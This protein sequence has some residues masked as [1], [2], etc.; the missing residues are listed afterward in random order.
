MDADRG[1]IDKD[2][3]MTPELF[4]SPSRVL[5]SRFFHGSSNVEPPRLVPK[6][7]H[8]T[9]DVLTIARLGCRG[10]MSKISVFSRFCPHSPRHLGTV[11][12]ASSCPLETAEIEMH[13]TVLAAIVACLMGARAGS[14]GAAGTS[15]VG[16]AGAGSQGLSSV[17][18]A[19]AN[20]A[21]LNNSGNDP[22]GAGNSTKTANVPGT[23]TAGT[24]N[25][26]G[27]TR[28]RSAI[29]GGHGTIGQANGAGVS[30]GGNRIDGTVTNGPLMR[31][32][33]TIRNE[34]AADPI[35]DKK[36]KCICRGC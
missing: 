33:K 4:Q 7:W 26:S 20:A 5:V 1:S 10:S 29:N 2:A 16:A 21:G 14:S 17:P 19:P 18:S 3:N 32:D 28:G 12:R 24:A 30:G 15:N 25:S 35:V 34:D 31:G 11:C 8:C 22:S 13:R 6:G 27:A 36:I 23:N 9:V